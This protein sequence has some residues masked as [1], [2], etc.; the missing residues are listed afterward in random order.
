LPQRA[1]PGDPVGMAVGR[2]ALR[3]LPCGSFSTGLQDVNL[4]E[5]QRRTLRELAAELTGIDVSVYES[6]GKDPLDPIVGLGDPD[7]RIGFFGRDPGRDEVEHGLPFI[8]A[9]GQK[10]RRT[11]YSH[12]YGEEMPDFA[13]SLRVGEHFFWINTVPYKPVNNKAW[14]MKVKRGFQPFMA[15][16]LVKSWHGTE[17]ITLGREAFLWFAINQPKAVKEQLEA[18]WAREDRFTRATRVS[19]TA[20]D[21]SAREFNLHPLP[22]PSPLN[23]VWYRRFPELLENRLRQ[24]EVRPDNLRMDA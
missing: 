10:V 16:L 11:L 13:A 22:H 23:A 12:L 18:F 9:G 17:V 4:P 24:L 6:C 5:Q 2:R 8:G 7:C 1:R 20:C 21:G 19:L 15:D 14:S 3:A